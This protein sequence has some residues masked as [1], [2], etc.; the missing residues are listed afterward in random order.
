M[1]QI[2]DVMQ[3]AL[4]GKPMSETDY[5]LRLFAAKIH[6]KVK[7]YDIKF[8]RETPIPDDPS[9]ADDVYKAAFDIVV[10]VGAYC[11]NTNRVISYTETEVKNALRF[12]PK[13]VW[14]GEGK[15]RKVL[16]ARSVGDKTPPWCLLGAGGGAC[17]SDKSFLTLVEGYAE[18]PETNGITTPALT[19]VGGMRIRP[20]SPL[21]VL[22]AQRN[23]VLFREAC[24]RVG[25]QGIPAMNTLSTAESDIA[26]AGAL[27]PKYGL[28]QSDAY[29]IC[30][31]DPMKV[32]FARLN[33]VTAVLGLGGAIGMCFGPMMGGYA[34]GPEGTTV[35]N[36]A[37]HM[38]GLLTYQT[39]WLLPF[40][41]HLRYVSSSCRELLWL[42]SVSSQSIARNT[43]LI[44]VNLN[45]T[46]AGPC[47]PMCLYETSASVTAAVTGGAH[48]ESVG[49]ASNK[50]ED[51]T[52]PVEPRISAEVGHAVA[53]MKLKDANELVLKLVPSY[54]KK[55]AD[56][57]L[58]KML[59][60]CWDAD[61]RCPT[62]DYIRVLRNYKSKMA[63]LGIELRRD[64]WD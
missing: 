57:P 58:G 17:S 56:P 64:P 23:A 10:D 2:L 1:V 46:S 11:T 15:D 61:N 51:R 62:K 7:E 63:D 35:S 27:H 19:R 18:I 8:D 52:T 44:S 49:V 36:V 60:E 34:G 25:R 31:M 53:G 14:L 48:I 45:Y 4:E 37:H 29:M 40:P 24:S 5:Q 33:K 39:S 21:E 54:E 38:M 43:P 42:I 20:A 16:K 9:L 41:L 30:C 22:G 26:L 13:E 3:K 28:R 55:L 32:D 47:T 59:F 6:E 50:Q 12:A